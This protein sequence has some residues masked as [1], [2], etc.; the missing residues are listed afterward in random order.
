MDGI[1]LQRHPDADLA[2]QG[3]EPLSNRAIRTILQR[4]SYQPG[5]DFYITRICSEPHCVFHITTT[6]PNS[7]NPEVRV[8]IL[9]HV[10]ATGLYSEA[11]L[12]D[13]V[14]QGLKDINN[15]EFDEWFRIDGK[16]VNDPHP[17]GCHFQFVPE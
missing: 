16:P 17:P 5:W 13:A 9:Y 12:V 4:L 8:N 3:A 2:Q 6:A 7:R 10:V 1:V 14:K 11:Q 15:H